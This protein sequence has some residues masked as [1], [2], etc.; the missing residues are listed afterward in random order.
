MGTLVERCQIL[1]KIVMHIR[2]VDM[3]DWHFGWDCNE[4]GEKRQ[5]QCERQIIN[6]SSV[7]IEF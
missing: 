3:Q 4:S 7:I 2:D 5:I 1:V 6:D